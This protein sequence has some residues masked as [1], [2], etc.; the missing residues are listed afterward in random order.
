MRILTLNVNG[1]RAA[2]LK[3]FFEWLQAQDAD[4]VCL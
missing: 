4:F 3:G 2:A 1:I